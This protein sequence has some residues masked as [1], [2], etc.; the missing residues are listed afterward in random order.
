MESNHLINSTI[1]PFL[2]FVCFWG[3]DGLVILLLGLICTLGALFIVVSSVNSIACSFLNIYSF[4][5]LQVLMVRHM[6]EIRTLGY[7]LSIFNW[8]SWNSWST[9]DEVEDDERISILAASF[10]TAQTAGRAEEAPRGQSRSSL[11]ADQIGE[12][13]KYG[14][15]S[16]SAFFSDYRESR[17]HFFAVM[18]LLLTTLLAVVES[19]LLAK[20]FALFVVDNSWYITDITEGLLNLASTII[21]ILLLLPVKSVKQLV[22]GYNPYHLVGT[23]VLIFVKPLIQIAFLILDLVLFFT[24]KDIPD[25]WPNGWFVAL[26]SF[27][28]FINCFVILYGVIWGTRWSAIKCLCKRWSRADCNVISILTEW[29]LLVVAFA[30]VVVTF[31]VQYWQARTSDI[32]FYLFHRHYHS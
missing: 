32:L 22:D 23:S 27:G 13:G 8:C 26:T 1:T 10:T 28:I 11:N 6:G 19:L 16:I 25:N 18:I 7:K 30:V 21:L 29:L 3:L 5:A 20:M 12:D 2:S 4:L 14:I 31:G 24:G 9:V 15:S 17:S